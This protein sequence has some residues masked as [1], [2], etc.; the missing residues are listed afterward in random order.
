MPALLE[1]GS[2]ASLQGFINDERETAAHSAER[3]HQQG[4]QAATALESRP[5]GA[6]EHLMVET[7][8]R[9][10]TLSGVSQGCGDGAPS[11]GQQGSDDSGAGPFARW[12]H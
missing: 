5:A 6:V 11:S 2:P 7:E 12:A 1:A 10:V 3:L 9:G 4:Q 8:R